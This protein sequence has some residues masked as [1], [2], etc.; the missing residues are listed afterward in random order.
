MNNYTSEHPWVDS[1]SN[2][3]CQACSGGQH[4]TVNTTWRK[5][6]FNSQVTNHSWMDKHNNKGQRSYSFICL[7]S[8]WH[9]Y[10]RSVCMIPDRQNPGQTGPNALD[11]AHLMPLKMRPDSRAF[12]IFTTDLG[13]VN[14]PRVK[15]LFPKSASLSSAAAA[16]GCSAENPPCPWW[17]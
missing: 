10:T 16:T 4:Q 5:N 2:Y 13:A 3:S 1:W 9:S 11:W 7:H 12:H 17:K 15:A 6:T 14:A 8:N